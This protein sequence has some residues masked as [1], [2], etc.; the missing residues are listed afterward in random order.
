VAVFRTP[1]KIKVIP[2]QAPA[3]DLIHQA[4]AQMSFSNSYVNIGNLLRA[5]ALIKFLFI[6]E[7]GGT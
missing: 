1:N 4:S 6:S 3:A 7:A 2:K 5:G